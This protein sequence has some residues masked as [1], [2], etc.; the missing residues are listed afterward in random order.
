MMADDEPFVLDGLS[1]E[2]QAMM[3]VYAL[4]WKVEENIDSIRPDLSQQESHL[5]LKLDRPKRMGVLACDMM[6][7]PSTLTT[8]ADALEKAGHIARQ[9]DPDDRRAWLLVLTEQGEEA[10]RDLIA[11]AGELFRHA[12]GLNPEE[13]EAFAQLARK[14]RDNILKTGIPEGLKK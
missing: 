10:R 1:P 3:G 2:I 9:R 5:L 7:A 8:A 6:M 4:Y 13:T 12:S 11:K 14:I